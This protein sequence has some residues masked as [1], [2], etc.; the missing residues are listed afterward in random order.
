M[1]IL[2]KMTMACGLLM[3]TCLTIYAADDLQPQVTQKYKQARFNKNDYLLVDMNK[4]SVDEV[5]T[6]LTSDIEEWKHS[7]VRFGHL[8]S[9]Q[10]EEILPYCGHI[11]HLDLK[12][13]HLETAEAKAI[14]QSTIFSHLQILNLGDN[15]ITDAGVEAIAQSTTLSHLTSLILWNNNITDAG[16]KAIAESKT[17]YNL[18]KLDLRWNSITDA[19]A[20]AIVNSETLS[21][22]TNLNMGSNKITDA[23]DKP[24]AN[25]LK[26]NKI[27]TMTL[28]DMHV[29]S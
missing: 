19:G 24:I 15:Q 18:I 29:L 22:L 6:H 12:D 20:I 14:A 2:K 27:R 10:L 17:L 3:G 4:F 13:N 16:A 21:H 26:N 7:A 9:G 5:I 1:M 8:K 11:I 28:E 23:A 25:F